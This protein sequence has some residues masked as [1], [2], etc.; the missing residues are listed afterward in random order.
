MRVRSH[1]KHTRA[2]SD[3]AHSRC[4]SIE[5]LTEIEERWEGDTSRSTAFYSARSSML[6]GVSTVFG[7]S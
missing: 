7:D 3:Q 2:T 5:T 6:S 4:A 1:I